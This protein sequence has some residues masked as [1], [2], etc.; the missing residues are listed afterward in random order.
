M[1]R[2]FKESRNQ[3]KAL[4]TASGMSLSQIQRILKPEIGTSVDQLEALAAVFQLSTYQ[5]LIPDLDVGNEQ[6]VHGATKAEERLYRQWKKAG[7]AAPPETI[8][9]TPLTI[10]TK[11]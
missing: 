6:V 9:R 3:P 11:A 2:H 7:S 8:E 4:A 5:L 10:P 1:E